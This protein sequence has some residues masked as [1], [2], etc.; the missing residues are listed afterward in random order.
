VF[1]IWED[2]E[3]A[4]KRKQIKFGQ[5]PDCLRRRIELWATGFYNVGAQKTIAVKFH[6]GI[7]SAFGNILI[8][9]FL[10][11]MNFNDND[12]T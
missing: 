9:E 10:F 3:Q 12:C 11:V 1:V 7:S 2:K 8:G 5:Q 4:D 6:K